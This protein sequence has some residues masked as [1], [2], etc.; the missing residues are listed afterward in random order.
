M[1]PLTIKVDVDLTQVLRAIA[2]AE[3]RLG[4]LQLDRGRDVPRVLGT[5][6]ALAAA[7]RRISRRGLLGL[8]WGRRAE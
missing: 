5:V 4:R 8:Q 2:D 6:A 3:A 1:A 7:P